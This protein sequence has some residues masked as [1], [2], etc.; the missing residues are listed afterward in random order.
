MVEGADIAAFLGKSGDAAF[1][2]LCGKHLTVVAALARAYTRNRGFAAVQPTPPLG[3]IDVADDLAAVLITATARTA[4]NP[5]QLQHTDTVG[6]FTRQFSSAF[7]GWS[8]AE[9]YVLNRYRKRAQ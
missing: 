8:L 6:P 9:T 3:G 5:E 1:V 2:T 7:T 4:A